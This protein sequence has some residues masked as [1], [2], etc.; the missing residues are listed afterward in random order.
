MKVI[1]ELNKT[2]QIAKVH[3]WSV[4]CTAQFRCRYVFDLIAANEKKYE[5]TWCYNECHHE[6]GPMDGDRGTIKK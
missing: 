5:V 2:I 4:R 1:G 3:V 6:K